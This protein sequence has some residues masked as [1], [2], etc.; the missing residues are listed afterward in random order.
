MTIQN[1]LPIC[2]TA[3]SWIKVPSRN[4]VSKIPYFVYFSSKDPNL[5]LASFMLD[6]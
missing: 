5:T 6:G 1:G 4:L 3:V 2:K